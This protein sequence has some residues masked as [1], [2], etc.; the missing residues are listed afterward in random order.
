[1]RANCGILA[2]VEMLTR[3]TIQR[4]FY[5]N[6]LVLAPDR[7]ALNKI[8]QQRADW[9]VSKDLAEWTT[10]DG[11]PAA[12]RLLFEPKNR[13]TNTFLTTPLESRCVACG[14]EERLSL[15]HIVPAV[16]RRAFP[17]EH[18]A[19]QHGWCMLLCEDDHNAADALAMRLYGRELGE[20]HAAFQ[21][22]ISERYPATQSLVALALI[23]D[24][25]LVEKVS[26]A[27]LQKLFRKAQV[28][29]F[30]QVPSGADVEA[31]RQ[32]HR[33][34]QRQVNSAIRKW[35]AAFIEA[36]GGVEAVKTAFRAEFLKLEPKFLP[37]GALED[38]P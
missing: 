28:T 37:E 4:P 10:A 11:Y 12:I 23:R 22:T 35:A 25:N 31:L 24:Q 38:H 7:Q 27:R 1:M 13:S 5:S 32:R 26:K 20:C 6:I 8:G 2:A 19:S 14:A 34:E 30:E 33:K 16:I 9:Y 15:H 17:R 3:G 21:R 18:K 36:R 29:S